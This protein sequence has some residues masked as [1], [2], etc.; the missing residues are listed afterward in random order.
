M[1]ASSFQPQVLRFPTERIART[2]SGGATQ[3]DIWNG[4]IRESIGRILNLARAPGPI[5]DMH[6][7]DAFTGHE[8]A[9]SVGEFFVRLSVDGH[10]YYFDRLTGKFNGTGSAL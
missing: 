3:L 6:V 10:H 9:L 4:H 8:V 7:K 5:K 1:A 2:A